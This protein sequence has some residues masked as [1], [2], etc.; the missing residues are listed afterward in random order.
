MSPFRRNFRL[1]P[2]FAL[3]AFA[4]LLGIAEPSRATVVSVADQVRGIA[5]T[6]VQCASLP[7]AVWLS[8]MSR[9][10]C[11]RYYLS[12]AG[13]EGARPVVFLQGDRL[14]RLNLKTGE[15]S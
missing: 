11:I 9:N 4:L 3:A 10:F 7:Q 8:V 1:R 13:G 15:F 2:I 12:T 5:M 14:G 6:Q